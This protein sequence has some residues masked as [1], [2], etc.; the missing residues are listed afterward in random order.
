[1]SQPLSPLEV[2]LCEDLHA[3]T[4]WDPEVTCACCILD[5][6]CR[7]L[8]PRSDDELVSEFLRSDPFANAVIVPLEMVGLLIGFAPTAEA[9]TTQPPLPGHL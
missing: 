1:M 3:L 6:V 2:D 8:R 7:H 5:E 9:P 4:D